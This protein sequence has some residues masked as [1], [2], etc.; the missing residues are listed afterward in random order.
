MKESLRLLCALRSTN[1][2]TSRFGWTT[3]SCHGLGFEDSG[4]EPKDCLES[5][6]V[7]VPRAATGSMS[8]IS[9]QTSHLTDTG[10]V[11]CQV[12]VN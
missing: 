1:G 2:L 5:F 3:L 10:F 9:F 6:L 4:E 12:P 7:S 11:V 8:V